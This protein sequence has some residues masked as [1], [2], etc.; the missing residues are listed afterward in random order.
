VDLEVDGFTPIEIIGRG[1]SATVYRAREDAFDREV[2]LKVFDLEFGPSEHQRFSR[3]LK[4]I[5]HLGEA[6]HAVALV[7]A[8]GVTQ[9]SNPFISMR[10]YPGG[11]L[12]AAVK[13]LGPLELSDAFVVAECIGGALDAAHAVGI[14]HRDVKPANVLLDGKRLAVL[15]DFGIASFVEGAADTSTSMAMMT[16]AYAAPERLEGEPATTA[17]DV[18]SLAAT[19]WSILAGRVPHASTTTDSVA[20]IINRIVRGDIQP[21]GRSDLP[22][23]VEPA[24][25]RGLER[26]PGRRP[27]SAGELVVELARPLDGFITSVPPVVSSRSQ[28]LWEGQALEDPDNQLDDEVTR[29][30]SGS[31]LAMPSVPEPVELQDVGHVGSMADPGEPAVTDSVAPHMY[32]PPDLPLGGE[33]VARSV[34]PGAAQ[35]WTPASG[36][37]RSPLPR[38]VLPAAALVVI[39]LTTVGIVAFRRGGGRAADVRVQGASVDRPSATDS[40]RTHVTTA[41]S[42]TSASTGSVVGTVPPVAGGPVPLGSPATDP[43]SPPTG[44]SLPGKASGAA[45]Q[46]HGASAPT[47]RARAE[48]STPA[49][50]TGTTKTTVQLPQSIT[51]VNGGAPVA[52]YPGLGSKAEPQQVTVSDTKSGVGTCTDQSGRG[53][54]TGSMHG[55]VLSYGSVDCLVDTSGGQGSGEIWWSNG[56]NTVAKSSV[57]FSVS[58]PTISI[59]PQ[60]TATWQIKSG[61]FAGTVGS[62]PVTILL[63]SHAWGCPI[64]VTRGTLKFGTLT[65]KA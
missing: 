29:V 13:R 44:A 18:Y 22:S 4:A 10:Y 58:V 28:P 60:G 12:Q 14:L 1:G 36:A 21:L 7:F 32:S 5:G 11:S 35:A 59:V 40:S 9:R 46:V 57:V 54:T 41:P 51:C 45:P 6:H 33:P 20:T 49:G 53:I 31:P 30:R 62:A 25:R 8:T 50:H 42:H 55:F 23:H 65:L 48:H 61:P 26:D 3:E 63:E 56:V 38:W 64:P 37:R 19:L 27:R 16:P 34:A 39:G 17:S 52:F 2:A 15:A 47:P 43:P 24:L